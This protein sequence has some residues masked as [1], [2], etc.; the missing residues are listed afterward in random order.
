MGI[1]I[2]DVF[3]KYSAKF[4]SFIWK[5]SFHCNWQTNITII[6][7]D[8]GNIWKSRKT[9]NYKILITEP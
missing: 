2:L 8:G 9:K 4:L 7:V 3:Y 6:L 1:E 5:H